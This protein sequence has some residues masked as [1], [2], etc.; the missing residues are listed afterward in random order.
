MHPTIQKLRENVWTLFNL[1]ARNC[2]QIATPQLEELR[3][4]ADEM[5]GNPNVDASYRV[6]AQ[7]A[8]DA[9]ALALEA[10]K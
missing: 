10:R 8:H 4:R 9:A 6:A 7:I 2:E 3:N 1:T 5:R